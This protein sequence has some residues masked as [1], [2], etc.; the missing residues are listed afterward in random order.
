MKKIFTLIA[1]V[2]LA[3]SAH[4]TVTGYKCLYTQAQ[5][6][7]TGAGEVYLY[8]KN[9]DDAKYIK[10][11][12]ED[13]GETAFLKAVIDIQGGW[14]QVNDCNNSVSQDALRI[15]V[16]P[17][18]LEGYELVCYANKVQEDGLYGRRDV[19]ATLTEEGENKYMNF[20]WSELGDVINVNNPDH[21]ENANS[22]EDD[23]DK[24]MPEDCLLD[25]YEHFWNTEP[26]TYVYVIFRAVGEEYPKF[27]ADYE[28]HV[29]DDPN[30]IS[31]VKTAA[32]AGIS[33]NLAGQVV[34]DNAKGIIVKDGKKYIAR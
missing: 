16:Y 19:Y 18:A 15:R 9:D 3:M 5:V 20:E 29:T 28:G 1:A 7:P 13:W 21:P 6:H 27:D 8:T 32:N 10:E 2:A 14:D 4:A 23:P 11:Y 30:G 12:S 31:Q 17:A 25:E 24:P 34:N 33:Y 26:D 22:A